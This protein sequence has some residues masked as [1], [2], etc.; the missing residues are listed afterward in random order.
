MKIRRGLVAGVLA[1]SIAA[2]APWAS[3]ADAKT[4]TGA[5]GQTAQQLVD[6]ASNYDTVV[7]TKFQAGNDLTINKPVTINAEAGAALK[8]IIIK[9]SGVNIDGAY[10]LSTT[11]G[12]RGIILEGKISDVTIKHVVFANSNW[13][14]AAQKGVMRNITLDSNVFESSI[15]DCVIFIRGI[16]N[17][18]NIY[19]TNN[20]S[21]TS[22]PIQIVGQN[23]NEQLNNVVVR[24]NKSISNKAAN[25][26]MVGYIKNSKITN[27]Y[28]ERINGAAFDN[29]SFSIG[30][31]GGANGLEISGNTSV[32]I[33]I[34]V[35][36]GQGTNQGNKEWD[37]EADKSR[38]ITIE[39]NTIKGAT[40]GMLLSN[41]YDK[42]VISCNTLENN[43]HNVYD[44]GS[45]FKLTDA[46]NAECKPSEP[47]KPDTD[48][49]EDAGK[50]EA[51]N[52]AEGAT[53]PNTGADNVLTALTMLTTIGALTLGGALYARKQAN[54]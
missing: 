1:L 26:V 18:A 31:F 35:Y 11:S 32:N 49:G 17:S 43:Q 15:K 53:A 10:N 25:Q 34:G 9:S 51:N 41:L 20:T 30:I 22:G 23:G 33:P 13:G 28:N 42:P 29:L 38:G 6:S 37:K 44:N 24:G 3:Q 19:V 4:I 40:Y 48:K 21:Y 52:N 46:D 45:G 36:V 54:K 2:M 27:N 12:D 8:Q 7:L 5:E 14:I 39:G 50:G 47:S 16:S